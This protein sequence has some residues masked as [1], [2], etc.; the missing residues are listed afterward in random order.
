VTAA[1][2]VVAASLLA[3]A[4]SASAAT[5]DPNT[6][7]R[8]GTPSAA[9]VNNTVLLLGINTATSAVAAHG[10]RVQL[11][12]PDSTK[13]IG[14]YDATNGRSE[15]KWFD[16]R[17][18][19]HL[20][21]DKKTKAS[22]QFYQ[23]SDGAQVA[24]RLKV[25]GKTSAWL[26]SSESAALVS[27]NGLAMTAALGGLLKFLDISSSDPS[28]THIFGCTVTPTQLTLTDSY[29][30]ATLPPA[31][32]VT[33]TYIL[34]IDAKGALTGGTDHWVDKSGN[35]PDVL[36][37]ETDTYAKATVK[38]P[39][40]VYTKDQWKSALIRAYFPKLRAATVSAARAK[41]KTLKTSGARIG[42]VRALARAKA[43]G[44]TYAAAKEI[45]IPGGAKV[46]VKDPVTK[47]FWYFTI[48]VVGKT[49][50]VTKTL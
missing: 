40:P 35:Y 50:Q 23:P 34:G 16:T 6:L 33:E 11:T 38:F 27:A 5:F 18:S 30:D 44:F 46:Q 28:V 3:G 24:A 20:I 15:L 32:S 39:S 43:K 19:G 14:T 49:V 22:Y 41:V 26:K 36:Y 45:N 4:G 2:S 13:D 8:N 42:A 37:T 21:L 31:P 10:L 1:C 12:G 7:C 25:L 9:D 47:K 48:K 17:S 29:V